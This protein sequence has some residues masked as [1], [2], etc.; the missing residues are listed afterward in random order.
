MRFQPLECNHR[1]TGI[2]TSRRSNDLSH[3]VPTSDSHDTMLF[4]N[5]SVALTGVSGLDPRLASEYMERLRG[6]PAGRH[7]PQI[8]EVFRNILAGCGQLEAAK[9]PELVQTQIMDNSD[10][11]PLARE[12][13]ILWY[14]ADVTGADGK[15]QTGPPEHFFRGLIWPVI[16][17]HPPALSG[18]FMGHWKYPPDS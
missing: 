2:A 12:I 18:G 4:V 13:I 1:L 3:D 5:L 16:Q 8:L 7:L 11:G 15:P 9:L 17:A 6:V 14:I 10:L